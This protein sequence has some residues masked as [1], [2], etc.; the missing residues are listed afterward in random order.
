MT[1]THP[2]THEQVQQLIQPRSLLVMQKEA[3][4]R[5][6]HAILPRKTDFVDGKAVQRGCRISL[7]FRSVLPG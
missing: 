6:K 3:R 5:W 7:T 2:E 1:F 4:Y